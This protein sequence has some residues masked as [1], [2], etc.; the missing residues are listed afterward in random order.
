MKN[1]IGS[2]GLMV[3]LVGCNA[4]TDVTTAART[5]GGSFNSTTS[6]SVLLIKQFP[7]AV[8]DVTDLVNGVASLKDTNSEPSKWVISF[9][10]SA[11]SN[12]VASDVYLSVYYDGK[13]PAVNHVSSLG[14]LRLYKGAGNSNPGAAYWNNALTEVAVLVN[15]DATLN[16]LSNKTGF[17]IDVTD[18]INASISAGDSVVTFVM[19]WDTEVNGTNHNVNFYCSY[20]SS[21]LAAYIP[22]LSGN[23]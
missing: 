16:G 14:S 3:V 19:K 18:S 10:I 2:L 7:S 6:K 4:S 17:R 23:F 12:A 11:L 5:T 9:D 21:I 22:T 8:V 15:S 13:A 1:V 20:T